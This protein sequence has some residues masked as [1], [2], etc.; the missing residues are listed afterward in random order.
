MGCQFQPSFG[1]ED[2]LKTF[3]SLV[4]LPI[5]SIKVRRA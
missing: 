5:L 4:V 2:C 3:L 1:D